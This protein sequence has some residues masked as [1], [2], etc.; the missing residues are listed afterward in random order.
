MIAA[1]QPVS[2]FLNPAPVAPVLPRGR[3]GEQRAPFVGLAIA[4]TSTLIDIGAMP[5]VPLT[6]TAN[7][8]FTATLKLVPESASADGARHVALGVGLNLDIA[9]RNSPAGAN[10]A[11]ADTRATALRTL[12]DA[13]TTDMLLAAMGGGASAAGT[14][15][16]LSRFLG[17][18][19]AT[20]AAITPPA[21]VAATTSVFGDLFAGGALTT[22]PASAVGPTAGLLTLAAPA[23]LPAAA[24]ATAAVNAAAQRFLTDAMA[25]A[26]DTVA[27]NPNY[28]MAAAALYFSTAVFRSQAADVTSSGLGR[29][30]PVRLVTP[31]Q[32]VEALPTS[33]T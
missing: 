17:A 16:L 33:V 23:T 9:V 27:N 15:D 8:T 31:T 20:T 2:G 26:H 28:A 4:D 10:V 22:L 18:D 11:L 12:S 21:T 6:Y 5:S 29:N 24:D 1:L 7:G 32:N 14:L 13:L 19:L 30:E 25:R 3:A